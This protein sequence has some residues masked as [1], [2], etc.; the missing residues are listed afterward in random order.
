MKVT[1]ILFTLMAA[2]AVSA[3]VLDKRDTCGAGYDPAQRRT[4]SPCQASNGDRHFCGCDRTG[5]IMFA[6]IYFRDKVEC[7]G[8]KWTEIQDCG[9][10]SCHGGTEGGA[11]C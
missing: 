9:R 1:A 5:I 2:T 11:K 4:N 8:G 3:S 7:K 10:N 6:N